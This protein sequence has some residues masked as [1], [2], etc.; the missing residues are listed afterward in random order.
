MAFKLIAYYLPQFHEIHENNVWWGHGFTEWNNVKNGKKL[1]SG[2]NQPLVPLNRNYYNLLEKSVVEWQ[3]D[4]IKKYGIYGFCYYHYW[5]NGRKILERPAENLLKW[6]DIKQNY[7]FCWA[8]H[9]WKKTWNGIN[10]ILITQD[11]GDEEDW[12]KHFEYL[13]NFFLDSRYIKKNKKPLLLLY[14]AKLIPKIDQF[15]AYLDAKCKEIGL[16]GI[17]II[18]SLNSIK[19]HKI[20]SLSNATVIREPLFALGKRNIIQ[21]TLKILKS[22][23]KRNYLY[24]PTKYD[25]SRVAKYSVLLS[26]IYSNKNCYPCVFPSWDNTSRHGRRGYVIAGSSQELW[27]KYLYD[28]KKIMTEK[29]I[30]YLFINAWN[31]W[32]EGMYLEPDEIH[33]YAYLETV[34]KIFKN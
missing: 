28:Q 2:H 17:C 31:E 20:S 9:S 34:R 12:E 25:Y 7:C 14:E 15:I 4:T 29:G 26:E 23:F 32:A 22:M 13:S 19:S 33:K 27:E 24:F 8:N 11:Y 3:T 16:D 10:E 21:K 5:F 30:E 6:Q 18:E 1:F